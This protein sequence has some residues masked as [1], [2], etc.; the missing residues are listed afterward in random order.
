VGEEQQWPALGPW[1]QWTAGTVFYLCGE[2]RRAEPLLKAAARR[3]QARQRQDL[4]DRIGL[5]L[6]D[7]YAERRQLGRARRLADR[8]VQRFSAA[9]DR[10]RLAATLANLGNAEEAADRIDTAI[11]L[12]RRA[13]SK[14][15]ENE[16][17]A[18][19]VTG[20][21]AGAAVLAGRF[22]EALDAYRRVGQMASA[23]GHEALV[24][25]AEL[26]T[27]E[28]EFVLGNVDD[29][30]RRWQDVAARAA[31]AGV[32]LLEVVAELD[33]AEAELSLGLWQRSRRRLEA[34][35]VELE[36]LGLEL[37]LAR[38]WRLLAVCASV[39]G[40]DAGP[41]EDRARCRLGGK[42]LGA[43]RDL[44]EVE[45]AMLECGPEPG[46]VRGASRRL[47]RR[48]LRQR[49]L[50]G[51]ALAAVHYAEAEAFRTGTSLAREVLQHR[52]VSPWARMTAHHAVARCSEGDPAVALRHARA[53]ARAAERLHGRLHSIADRSAFLRLRAEVF[54]DLMW[55]LVERGRQQDLR[56]CLELLSTLKAG[57]LIDELT[58][59][60]DRGD[61]AVMRRWQSL[62]R[63]LAALVEHTEGEEEPRVRRLRTVVH[64]EMRQLEDELERLEIRLGRER[65]GLVDDHA[66]SRQARSLPSRLPPG[67]L[68]VEYLFH[69]DVLLTVIVFEHS[70]RVHRQAGVVAEL[71]RLIDSVCFHADTHTWLAGGQRVAGE[72]NLNRRLE[73]LGELLLSPIPRRGW[74]VLW[75]APDDGLYHLPWA[76]LPF[77]EGCRLIDRGALTMVPGARLATA[78]LERDNPHPCSAA[79]VGA[80]AKTLRLIRPE[81]EALATDLTGAV[82]TAEATRRELLDALAQHE[83]VHVAAH[84]LFLDGVP[85][86]SGIRLSD[87]FVSLHDLAAATINARLVSFGVCSGVRMQ[88]IE[89]RR[90]EGFLRVLLTAGVGH[91]VGPTGWVTDSCAHRFAVT[92]FAELRRSAQPVRAFQRAVISVRDLDPHPAAWGSFQL[93][94]DG[95]KWSSV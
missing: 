24:I 18:L 40:P 21:L 38:A 88:E 13:L 92:F 11:R 12:W 71:R 49:G 85:G 17:E 36:E 39:D 16:L 80:G 60:A 79:V 32:P 3:F 1:I 73:R 9:G 51:L 82:A 75:L 14:L 93:Y 6:L 35:V 53:A 41:L 20:N 46:R 89:T 91:V 67:H 70:V 7:L 28:A 5:I 58:R 44:L 95:R 81:V 55:R 4:G 34:L 87:G 90:F 68:Y 2:A 48:G 94:G 10:R 47:L 26:N 8:L 76:A 33:V 50:L 23:K 25:Q 57:W 15:P 22:D 84:A 61:D 59:R 64:H 74:S 30:L 56:Q 42:G 86:A 31:A 69:G 43:Q 72:R 52:R 62:S 63:R 65:P 37:E 29:A 78:L 66:A 27:A 77:S 54:L 45:L 19:L 83:I